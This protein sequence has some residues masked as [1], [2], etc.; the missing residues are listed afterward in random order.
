MKK[1]VV[2]LAGCLGKTVKVKID[3]KCVPPKTFEDYVKLYLLSTDETLRFLSTTIF[4]SEPIF[5]EI[6]TLMLI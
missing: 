4:T 3:G 6:V 2:D 1:R 5:I